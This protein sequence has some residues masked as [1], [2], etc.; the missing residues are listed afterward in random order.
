MGCWVW[1]V[2]NGFASHGVADTDVMKLVNISV[3]ETEV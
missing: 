2:G 1:L 3:L